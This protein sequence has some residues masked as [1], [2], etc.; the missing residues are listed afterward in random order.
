M[1]KI[2]PNFQDGWY[3]DLW[4]AN[5]KPPARRHGKWLLVT[6]A[7]LVTTAGGIALATAAPLMSVVVGIP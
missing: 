7:F 2:A 3:D 5:P 6:L 1:A 4:S